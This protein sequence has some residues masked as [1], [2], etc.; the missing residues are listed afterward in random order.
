MRANS[1]DDDI[2][3]A[4]APGDATAGRLGLL[5]DLPGRWVG[6]GLNL[7]ARPAREGVSRAEPFFLQVNATTETLEF[8][9]IG[10]DIAN[11]GSMESTV[12][13]H[14]L[15][16]LQTIVDAEDQSALHVEPGFWLRV[17]TTAA[18][19]RESYV[20]HATAPHGV[21][22]IARSHHAARFAGGPTILPIETLPFTMERAIPALTDV[23][24]STFRAPYTEPYLRTPLPAACRPRGLAAAKTIKDP[25]EMLRAHLE[26]Q[27]IMETV[28]IEVTTAGL[29]GGGIVSIPFVVK[30]A[31]VPQM[32]AI[33]WL[34]TVRHPRH[35]EGEFLQLQ[36]VQRVILDFAGA[37]WPH[38]SVGTLVKTM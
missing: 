4:G 33:F 5:E 36:Y 21:S 14:G 26:G 11:R 6:S 34:E 1:T 24:Q 10:G 7:I 38:V 19:T 23:R 2:F 12:L 25:T 35:P 17:P 8:A 18:S 32:D 15:R 20:R 27:R 13:T 37:H 16:Y 29:Q 3:H 31:N 22:L 28:V 30:N 9:P